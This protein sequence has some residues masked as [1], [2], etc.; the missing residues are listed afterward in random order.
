MYDPLRVPNAELYNR[1]CAYAG[2]WRGGKI[3]DYDTA[4]HLLTHPQD[5]TSTYGTGP[6]PV[7]KKADFLSL[8]LS[9]PPEH[10]A[11]RRTVS[12]WLKERWEACGVD[13][14]LQTAKRLAT[15]G[16]DVLADIARPLPWVVLQ[17]LLQIPE[18][19]QAEIYGC[20]QNIASHHSWKESEE[21]LLDLLVQNPMGPLVGTDGAYLVRLL[22]LAGWASTSAAIANLL[23]HLAEGECGKL[24]EFIEESLR[25]AS[26]IS[27]F[28]RQV[29]RTLELGNT[30]LQTGDRV[31]VLFPAVNRDP[32]HFHEPDEFRPGRSCPHL[33]F[34]AGP[35]QCLGADIARAQLR[36][37]LQGVMK[38]G[39]LKI[40]HQSPT[41]SAFALGPGELR[42]AW[43]T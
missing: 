19:A 15:A 43:N 9:D 36:W 5:F 29:T 1:I 27:Q 11:L 22:L 28:S 34:G 38:R 8:N 23:M 41:R 37:V 2:Q 18:A 16:P 33:A 24:E 31:T 6:G 7:E 26:P 40:V 12:A 14:E 35:H 17:A 39:G 21:R 20:V 4:R 42:V 10:G 30:H 25:F 13:L 3:G 32:K